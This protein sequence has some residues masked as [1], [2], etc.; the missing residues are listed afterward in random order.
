M[1]PTTVTVAALIDPDKVFALART[2][3]RFKAGLDIDKVKQYLLGVATQMAAN[4]LSASTLPHVEALYA[5]HEALYGPRPEDG[6]PMQ[7]DWENLLDEAANAKFAPFAAQTGMGWQGEYLDDCQLWEPQRRQN[8]AHSFGAAFVEGALGVTDDVSGKARKVMPGKRLSAFGITQPM[9]EE[10]AASLGKP[11]K[12]EAKARTLAEATEL[13]HGV[14]QTYAAAQGDALDLA[15]FEALIEQAADSDD[16]L[17]GSALVGLDP[18]AEPQETVAAFR[19][20]RAASGTYMADL[21]MMLFTDV[22][23]PPPE[24]TPAEAAKAEKKQRAP[25][26]EPKE[27]KDSATV[28]SAVLAVFSQLGGTDREMA[29][30]FGVQRPAYNRAKNGEM[31]LVCDADKIAAATD[32]LREQAAAAQ[33]AIMRLEG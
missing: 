10:F 19:T 16:I 26:R 9:I 2:Q 24:P 3:P 8:L 6:D 21:Q 13:V 15:V 5:E 17:A 7:E 29:S 23:A 12:P 20:L 22:P 32:W 30:L 27:V 25:R 14:I 31:D 18:R 28:P 11:E 4:A 33:E 1:D